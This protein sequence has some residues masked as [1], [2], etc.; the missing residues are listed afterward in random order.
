MLVRK[1]RIG[2]VQLNCKI[3]RVAQTPENMASSAAIFVIQLEHSILV[4]ERE[5]QF[6]VRRL[7][8]G[9]CMCPIIPIRSQEM[10]HAPA[11]IAAGF[12]KNGS[13]C[14]VEI[15]KT[16]PCPEHIKVWVHDDDHVANHIDGSRS[17]NI[18]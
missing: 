2:I 10:G 16:V 1:P 8:D 9:V 11:C 14:H 13:P 3:A 6:T 7:L 5:Q 12:A 15:I 17:L 4:T 18:R